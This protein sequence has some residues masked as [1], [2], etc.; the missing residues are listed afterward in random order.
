M[1]HPPTAQFH[2]VIVVLQG[3]EVGL[4]RRG[5]AGTLDA[6]KAFGEQ[7]KEI[8][9]NFPVFDG[10]LANLDTYSKHPQEMWQLMFTIYAIEN[11]NRQLRKVTKA[12]LASPSVN[13]LLKILYL[14]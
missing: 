11:F 1:N 4:C 3:P 14:A 13:S 9:E 10:P 2:L 12:K 8:P 7:Q 6:L 5:Q